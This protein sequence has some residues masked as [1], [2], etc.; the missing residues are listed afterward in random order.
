MYMNERVDQEL[1][2]F[3]EAVRENGTVTDVIRWYQERKIQFPMIVRFATMIF[4][5][6]HSQAE[7]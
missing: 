1:Y 6:L 4:S 2:T 3:W 7:N 5:I